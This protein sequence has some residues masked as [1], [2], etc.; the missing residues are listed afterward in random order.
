[1]KRII[2]LLLLVPF[3]ACTP[4]RVAIAAGAGVMAVGGMA[5]ASGTVVN[6]VFEPI[7]PGIADEA[8]DG[9]IVMLVGGALLVALGIAWDAS[10]HRREVDTTAGPQF[11]E[12]PRYVNPDLVVAGVRSWPTSDAP[13]TDPA[14][15]GVT[16]SALAAAPALDAPEPTRF[17][18][19]A[20]RIVRERLD[21]RRAAR[22]MRGGDRVEHAARADRAG[23]AGAPRAHRRR[24]GAVPRRGPI[25]LITI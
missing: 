21:Y 20:D 10:D 4:G 1:V 18:T 15:T 9:G 3:T 7:E 8:V 16:P 13:A 22:S 25:A 23:D 5:A 19:P 11:G 14:L 2:A 12:A 24:G 17:A 6:G